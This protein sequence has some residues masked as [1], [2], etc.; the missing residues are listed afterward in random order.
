M[1]FYAYKWI[2]S[3]ILYEKF[4]LKKNL[5]RKYCTDLTQVQNLGTETRGVR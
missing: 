4:D 5:Y 1:S 2:Q 3:F